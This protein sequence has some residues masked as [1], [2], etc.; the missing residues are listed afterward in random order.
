M[1]EKARQS[2]DGLLELFAME[3]NPAAPVE[4]IAEVTVI[5]R[6]ATPLQRGL[7]LFT[8]VRGT[9]ILGSSYTMLC[10][11]APRSS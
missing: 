2:L 11:I 6:Q 1:H 5:K 4:A 8:E 3:S 7:A 10:I 9:E